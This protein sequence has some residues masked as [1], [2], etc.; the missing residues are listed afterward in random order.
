MHAKK[1]QLY[2]HLY[3]VLT[4][5]HVFIISLIIIIPC[6]FLNNPSLSS[7]HFQDKSLNHWHSP[8]VL[9]YSLSIIIVLRRRKAWK[10]VYLDT[11]YEWVSIN[12]ANNNE[13]VR[14]IDCDWYR[15][16]TCCCGLVGDALLLGQSIPYCTL[17]FIFF[18][19]LFF[20]IIKN[21][22]KQLDHYYYIGV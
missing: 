18:L 7:A 17:L 15:S 19:I 12:D 5:I 4:D 8:F 6:L 22:G 13:L 1:L 3:M 21:Q 9:L 20:R 2:S 14:T 10:L 11:Y 16:T